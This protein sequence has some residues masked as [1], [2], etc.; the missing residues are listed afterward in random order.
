MPVNLSPFQYVSI[1]SENNPLWTP[2]STPG[3]VNFFGLDRR[4]E[5]IANVVLFL[6]REC[7]RIQVKGTGVG[8][9]FFG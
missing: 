6:E 7:V 8:R 3:P 4:E 2:I 5:S 9:L 1:C